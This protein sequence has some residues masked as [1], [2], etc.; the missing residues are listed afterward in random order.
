MHCCDGAPT[1]LRR[2]NWPVQFL[3][4]LPLAGRFDLSQLFHL[5]ADIAAGAEAAGGGER[6]IAAT[7]FDFEGYGLTEAS[8][9][10]SAADAMSKVMME[11]D[12]WAAVLG[13]NIL[14]TQTDA[15]M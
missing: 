5:G 1:I 15:V 7:P 2:P 3:Y 10:S 14:M 12:I 11:P 13:E 4:P 9:R 6:C 8:F